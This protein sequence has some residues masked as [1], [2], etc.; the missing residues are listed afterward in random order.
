MP[1]PDEHLRQLTLEQKVA[2]LAGVDSWHT[3]GFES[4][5]VPS[6]RMSD[7]PAGVRG[8]SRHGPAS[9]SFPCGAALGATF[10]PALVAEVGRALAREAHTKGA[11]LLLA[12]TVNLHRTPV[13][14]RNF[15][16]YSE[17]P[18]LTS[19]LA[20]AYITGVQA[21]TDGAARVAAC[22]KHLVA[23]DTEHER[24][25]I[26]SEVD[27]TVLRELY[28][29][30]F[31][32]AVARA[33]VRAVM[34]AYNRLNGTY[35]SEHE[36]LLTTVLRDEWG[37]DGLVVSDWYGTHSAGTSL[38]AGL[39]V[40]MPGPPNHRGDKLLTAIEAGEADEADVDRAAAR[41]LSLADW[42]GAA[43]AAGGEVTDVDDST[44]DVI[45]RAAIAGTVLLR[46]EGAA[47][48][49]AAPA[50]VALIGPYATTGRPQGGG[51][52]GVT[53][54]SRP[55]PLAALRARGFEV[56]HA[57][58]PSIGKYPPTLVAAAGVALHAR[59]TDRAGHA[60]ELPVDRLAY[61]WDQPPAGLDDVCFD[62]E[63]TGTFTPDASGT[64]EFGLHAIGGCTLSLDDEPVVA[65]PS[66][67]RGGTFYGLG[68]RDFRGSVELEAGR[69]YG[70][71]VDYPI[72]PELAELD[73]RVPRGL[74]AGARLVPTDDL[75]AAA[76]GVAA[77]ADVA[78]VIVGTDDQWE[79]EGEDR[80]ALQLPGEQDALVAAVTA[81]NPN[82][83]VVLNAGSP[84]TMPW[85]A[86]V[87]AVVQ[88]WFPGQELGDALADVL[89][90]AAD[91]AGRL[92]LTFPRQLADT[93][94]ATHHP[95]RDGK[96]VYG[97][98]LLIGYRWYDRRD[99]EPL[100]P[101]G[102][103]LSY[104]SF[105]VTVGG[106]RGVPADGVTV[107]VDVTNTGSRAGSEVVQV[108]VEQPDTGAD[109]P[110]R[111]L[112][113]FAKVHLEPGATERVEVNVAARAFSRWVSGA[114]TIPPG[115]HALA[116]GRSSRDL[117]GRVALPTV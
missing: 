4:P 29:P 57:P 10:D 35:C 74:A 2:L 34:S 23:N 48:P 67:E 55:G 27:E 60:V 16:C 12:P 9:A 17:D 105:D 113:G 65:V 32:A 71:R 50:K 97:E 108:Y 43:S 63:M 61:F 115:E 37:F 58:G 42:T 44:R 56:A 40:E 68:S 20:V 6:I 106:V 69:T 109:R 103:G 46:N 100:F 107:G 89:T 22:V 36:W 87:P 66:G 47:L 82:T 14:G 91:P 73:I 110:V 41:V 24:M 53:P 79:T 7:G 31:E 92:P 75:V 5:P 64:W 72:D 99:I 54:E 76:A 1:Q 98:G 78:V 77:A 39:D 104:T 111:T 49:L 81:A 25:T 62:V 95:G 117:V 96:A 21:P 116:V 80:T 101:F 45:R 70:L 86:Q 85:L 3:A 102:H 94:A 18:L 30:P 38:R 51:S 112:G 33:G 114:W 83:V 15:E 19:E 11:H 26:S 93:P 13:G 88:L 59:L 90:G 84:V 28:L 52:A 8:T